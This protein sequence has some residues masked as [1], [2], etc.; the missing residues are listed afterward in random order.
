MLITIGKAPI[1]RQRFLTEEEQSMIIDDFMSRY[2]REYDYYQAVARL[3]H[4]QC[5]TDLKHEGIRAIVTSRAKSHDSLYKKL[6]QRHEKQSYQNVKDIYEDIVDLAGVRIALY[7]PGDG[8]EVDKLIRAAFEVINDKIF[9]TDSQESHPQIDYIKR[10]SGYKARHYRVRLKAKELPDYQKRYLKACIEIQVA[11]VL[12][13]AWAEVEHDLVYKPLNGKLSQEEL[14]ILDQIN[15]LVI[16]GEIALEQLQ[17]AEKTR[18]EKEGHHFSNQYEV[19]VYL[20]EHLQTRIKNSRMIM[21][22][23]DILFRFLQVIHLDSPGQIQRFVDNLDPSDIQKSIAD[24]L[25]DLITFSNKE[26]LDVYTQIKQ[27]AEAHR[28]PIN[29]GYSLAYFLS[30]WFKLE[31]VV[32]EIANEIEH[33]QVSAL[34]TTTHLMKLGVFEKNKERYREIE[35]LRRLR[36]EVVHGTGKIDSEDVLHEAGQ[37]LGDLLRRIKAESSDKVRQVIDSSEIIQISLAGIDMQS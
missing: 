22:R 16:T 6:E 12:M 2:N 28:S 11:S 36:N 32:K 7:F 8:D 23:L 25:V 34:P 31:M 14:A 5:E 26:Y 10:F 18:I 33:T 24:Q 15:G 21:G 19:A 17:K 30:Q 1:H 20:H 13:H 3:C 35:Q 4:Q 37:M 9:P 27:E 29:I